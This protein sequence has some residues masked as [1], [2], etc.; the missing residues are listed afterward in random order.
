MLAEVLAQPEAKAWLLDRKIVAN[1]VGL[2]LVNETRS[3]L[4]GP[5]RPHAWPST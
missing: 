5:R 3:F 2:G 4:D 1:E